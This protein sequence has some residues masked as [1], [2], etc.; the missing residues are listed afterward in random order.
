MVSN[1]LPERMVATHTQQM[2]CELL[3]IVREQT[4]SL[5]FDELFDAAATHGDHRQSGGAS[6][7]RGDAEGFELAGQ[8]VKVTSRQQRLDVR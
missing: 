6:F 7:Q 3:V 2:P 8:N 1:A 5:V 4:V